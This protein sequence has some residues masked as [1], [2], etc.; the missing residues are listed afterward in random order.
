[1]QHSQSDGLQPVPVGG[2]PAPLPICFSHDLDTDTHIC[3]VA[4]GV[5]GLT[6]SAS[7]QTQGGACVYDAAAEP[8]LV[9]KQAV[10]L[11]V[12]RLPHPR[13]ARTERAQHCA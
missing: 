6:A 7:M 11:A 9:R 5:L 13:T 12:E 1:M 10:M 2:L 8:H 3:R 4:H